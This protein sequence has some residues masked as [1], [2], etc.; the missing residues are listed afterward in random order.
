MFEPLR[1]LP[2]WYF[3]LPC[4]YIMQTF[5]TMQPFFT[6]QPFSIMQQSSSYPVFALDIHSFTI[7]IHGAK[8][9]N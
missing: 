8:P 9:S 4:F 5:S 6:M 7:L 1:R 2:L 3:R